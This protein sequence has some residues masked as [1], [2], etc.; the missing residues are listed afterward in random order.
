LLDCRF[1]KRLPE[2]DLDVDLTVGFETLALVGRSGAG[3]STTLNVIAGLQPPDTGAVAL[4]GRTLVDVDARTSVAP[5]GR[6]IGYLFQ[7]YALF[8]HL[9]V[10]RNVGFGLFR[11][12]RAARGA[13]VREALTFVGLSGL[14]GAYPTQLSGGERQ[15]VALARALVTQPDALLLDEPLAALDVESRA[16]IRLELRVLLARLAIPTI[17]V[18]HDFDDARVLG[19][20]IAAMHLGQI[21]QMG[22]A[23]DLAAHPVDGFVAAL[24][25]TNR[26][27]V[28]A[29]LRKKA[30]A[31]DPWSARLSVADV[32]AA[33]QWRGKIVDMRPLGA[34][35]RV[36]LRGAAGIMVDVAADAVASAGYQVGDVVVAWVPERAIRESPSS[37]EGA[38]S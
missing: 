28:G 9:D 8:P 36:V 5:E 12:S 6:R 11:S 25:G 32:D 3:K 26:V 24:T 16:R 15:R 2:F 31:F 19:D 21:V 17:V 38:P 13:R 1:R 34:H 18:S 29:G 20:R 35:V 37:S 14:D 10:A 23:A 30:V 22:T 4:A 7:D 27:V 33:Y